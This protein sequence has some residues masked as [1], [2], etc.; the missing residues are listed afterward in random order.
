MPATRGYNLEDNAILLSRKVL[1]LVKPRLKRPL[2]SLT[3]PR[4]S[5]NL[6]LVLAPGATDAI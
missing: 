2:I 1:A 3:D 5:D 6:R 4:Q